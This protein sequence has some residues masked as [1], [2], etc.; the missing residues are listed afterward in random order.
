MCGGSPLIWFVFLLSIP[1][2]VFSC[3][4]DYT[5]RRMNYCNS[6]SPLSE[7][8]YQFTHTPLITCRGVH[9]R[10]D[11]ICN[12]RSPLCSFSFVV[13]FGLFLFKDVGEI[14]RRGGILIFS[15]S[16]YELIFAPF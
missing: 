8:V 15:F 11:I 14:H 1:I 16:P 9:R 7:P 3:R 12:S 10:G 13:L 4:G 6:R 5:G 2:V